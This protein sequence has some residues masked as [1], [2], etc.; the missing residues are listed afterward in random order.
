MAREKQRLIN[1][2]TGNLTSMPQAS[3]VEYGEIVVRHNEQQPELLIKV[4]ESEF[5]VIPGSGAVASAIS[6][7]T[8][9]VKDYIDGE[10]NTIEGN[11][12]ELREAVSGVSTDIGQNYVSKEDFEQAQGELFVSATTVAAA[13]AKKAKEDAI[14]AAAAS[15]NTL[16]KRID[17][18]DGK[19]TSLSSST[20][21][22]K[23]TADKAVQT[24]SIV[25]NDIYKISVKKVGTELQFDFSNLVIDGGSF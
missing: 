17:T 1:Y 19:V 24:A 7:A 25:D 5:G 20:V 13:D 6:A 14:A 9:G 18:V 21:T 3:D 22:I 16:N 10:V 23:A 4:S 11:I 2:H 15:A 8:K 12:T